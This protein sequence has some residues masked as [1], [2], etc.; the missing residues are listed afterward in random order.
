MDDRDVEIKGD[1]LAGKSFDFVV[2]GGVA[3]VEVPKIIRELRRYGA[4]V[5][6]IMSEGA[7][8]FVTP[9]LFEWASKNAVVR[10]LTGSAE[11]ISNADAVLIA[12]A[13]LDFISRVAHGLAD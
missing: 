2:S 11:H 7:H 1:H 6:V 5:R 12:P 3:S 13:T 8:Q 10:A 9:L 4:N